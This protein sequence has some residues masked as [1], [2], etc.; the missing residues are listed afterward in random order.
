MLVHFP[1]IAGFLC[2]NTVP[3]DILIG[4]DKGLLAYNAMPGDDITA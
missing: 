1:T 4:N 3:I 2:A